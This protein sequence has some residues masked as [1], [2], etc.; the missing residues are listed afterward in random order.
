MPVCKQPGAAL[1]LLDFRHLH[2]NMNILQLL[3]VDFARALVH[4]ARST[5]VLRERDEVTDRFF[6]FH[7]SD[8]AVETEGQTAV[9]RSAVLEGVDE[10]A[11]L[12]TPF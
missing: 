8:N 11:E 5:G 9:R 2:G 10:E 12:F 4:R 1:A 6:T 7:G 3:E